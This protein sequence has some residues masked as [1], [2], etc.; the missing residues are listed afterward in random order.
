MAELCENNI[1]DDLIH[2][3]PVRVRNTRERMS[4]SSGEGEHG[5]VN[6]PYLN[7]KWVGTSWK[8]AKDKYHKTPCACGNRCRTHCLCDK[9]KAMCEECFNIHILNV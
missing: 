1:D 4:V 3:S 6:R 2:R 7:S 5:L 8:M 9:S